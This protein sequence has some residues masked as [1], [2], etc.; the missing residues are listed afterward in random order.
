MIKHIRAGTLTLKLTDGKGRFDSLMGLASRENEKR[1]FLFVSKVLGKHVP[2]RPSQMRKSYNE[3]AHLCSKS[4]DGDT[5]VIGMAETATGLGAGVADSLG[6]LRDDVSI[7]YQHTTRH[8][9]S[10]HEEWFSLSESHSHAVDHILYR[11]NSENYDGIMDCEY[12]VLVDDEM[13]TGKT[14]RQLAMGV[15]ERAKKLKK[16]IIVTLANWLDD[17]GVALFSALPVAVEFI[18]IIRGEFDFKS[19]PNFVSQLPKNVDRDICRDESRDDLGRTGLKMPCEFDVNNS[20]FLTSSTAPCVVVGTGE[21]LFYPFLLAEHLE[22][23]NDVVFQSTTRSPILM[24][25]AI[26]R[27]TQFSVAQN[28][29]NYI[30]NL[31]E[32]RAVLVLC[33]N[34]VFE[35]NNGLFHGQSH[36][37]AE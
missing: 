4:L 34:E 16:V 11:P 17:D 19:N 29:V 9:L 26:E 6:R 1:G 13:T 12:L 7:Y 2:V 35:N 27:K 37:M 15:I 3:L 20:D 18:Q 32:D 30:Y 33:E 10:S 23:T 28:K 31:P 36:D 21:H 25:G 14:L 5:Y 8:E 22:K 24:G